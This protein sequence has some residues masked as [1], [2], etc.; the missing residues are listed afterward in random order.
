MSSNDLHGF[1]ERIANLLRN[2]ARQSGAVYGLQ[3]VQI[4][5][6]SYLNKCN[7]YSNTPQAVTD[8]L[9]LTKG[10][11]SQTLKILESNGFIAKNADLKD[12]RVIH[13]QLTK[14][15]KNIVEK[16]IPSPL[17]T[18]THDQMDK[19]TQS[20]LKKNL[21][22]FLGAMQQSNK[23][24]SFGVCHSCRYHRENQKGK[25][26]CELT[27]ERLLKK[28]VQLICREHEYKS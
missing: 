7:R 11:V 24:K 21:K 10:T 15:G 2:E 3:P 23:M 22:T 8:Y 12:K 20:Q 19:T 16:L 9:G 13:L 5:A 17:F 1:I 14:S 26:F 18:E 28:E 25:Y 27:Q 6:L 4:E